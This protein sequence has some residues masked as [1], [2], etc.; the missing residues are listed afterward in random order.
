MCAHRFIVVDSDLEPGRARSASPERRNVRRRINFSEESDS[1]HS[2]ASDADH[3][4]ASD[5]DHSMASDADHSVASDADLPTMYEAMQEELIQREMD[6]QFVAPEFDPPSESSSSEESDIDDDEL[7][8]E[9]EQEE[10][11]LDE[12]ITENAEEQIKNAL[13]DRDLSKFNEYLDDTSVKFRR[14]L[15]MR[16]IRR[17][18]GGLQLFESLLNS[19]LFDRRINYKYTGLRECLRTENCEYASLIF[20]AGAKSDYREHWFTKEAVRRKKINFLNLMKNQCN[21]PIWQE[22]ILDYWVAQTNRQHG[23]FRVIERADKDSHCF[24]RL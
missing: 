2:V 9:I 11:E 4:V 23:E 15:F 7:D 5:A 24:M 6:E 19:D 16:M 1:D 10:Q 22:G 17:K 12:D 21:V 18:L 20:E 13:R 3:S 8:A 14:D